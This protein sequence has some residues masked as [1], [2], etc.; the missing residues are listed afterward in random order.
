MFAAG[1]AAN[2]FSGKYAFEGRSDISS[3]IGSFA[4][5][6]LGNVY[7]R[8]SKESPFVSAPDSDRDFRNMRDSPHLVLIHDRS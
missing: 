6:F 8:L 2:Y 4:V 7:G 1:F 3:A 5:G